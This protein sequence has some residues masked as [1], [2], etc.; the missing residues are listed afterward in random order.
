MTK[1]TVISASG[2]KNLELAKKFEE[3]LIALGAEVSLLNL[4]TLELPLY[5]S[6]SD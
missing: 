1:I 2:L 4:M 6:E 3:Q 5:T